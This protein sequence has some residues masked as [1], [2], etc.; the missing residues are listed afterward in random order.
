M[1]EKELTFWQHLDVLRG[2]IIRCLVAVFGFGIVA[3]CLKE[4]LFKFVFWP[5]K[6]SFPLWRLLPLEHQI[7]FINT[8]L[9]QQ[10]MIHLEV[11]MV[12]GAIVVSPYILYELIRFISPALYP[13]ERKAAWPAV[14]S[15]Y[16]MFI[17]GMMLSYFVIFPVTFRFLAEYQVQ[18]S[19]A[20]MISLR[21]YI[22]TMMMLSFLLGIVFEMPIVCY[23]LGKLGLLHA[24]P[25]ARYRR[26]AIVAIL[27][28]SAVITPTGDAF[29]LSLVSLPIYL[30]YEVSILVVK[31]QDRLRNKQ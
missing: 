31:R 29:T 9:T 5:T 17:L 1:A 22:S 24:E 27:I 18:D 20:N 11:A 26:H 8:E 7:P 30:L 15:G 21:S 3:F 2:G 14:I 6:A 10:F 25:M 4:W 19:V 28:I 23:V 16:T 13:E 12:A